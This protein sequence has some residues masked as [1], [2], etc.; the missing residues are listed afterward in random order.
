MAIILMMSEK[1]LPQDFLKKVFWNKGYDVITSVND[2]TENVI[3][4]FELYCGCGHMIK[5]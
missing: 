4:W 5:I 3:M 1:W 2:V